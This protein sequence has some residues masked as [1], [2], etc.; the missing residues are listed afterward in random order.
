MTLLGKHDI[1]RIYIY[2]KIAKN[3]RPKT[4]EV[5]RYNKSSTATLV[6]RYSNFDMY[7]FIIS[8]TLQH[9]WILKTNDK[10]LQYDID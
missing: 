2:Y 9:C 3:N 10:N 1:S 5:I 4:N 6:Y 8:V 7:V